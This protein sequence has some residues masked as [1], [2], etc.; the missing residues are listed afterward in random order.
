M[1]DFD[2]RVGLGNLP[3]TSYKNLRLM[4]AELSL[5]LTDFSVRP[6]LW[7]LGVLGFG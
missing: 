7:V 2:K 4:S 5:R 6:L 1:L 3:G